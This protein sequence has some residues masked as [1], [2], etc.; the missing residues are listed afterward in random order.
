M[1]NYL[2]ALHGAMT[3]SMFSACQPN[4]ADTQRETTPSCLVEVPCNEPELDHLTKGSTVGADIVSPRKFY[5]FCDSTVTIVAR[6]PCNSG[7]IYNIRSITDVKG[8]E[9]QEMERA[10]AKYKAGLNLK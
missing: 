2:L 3:L 8:T 5:D 10:Y 7:P 1:K 9:R 4:K 6:R